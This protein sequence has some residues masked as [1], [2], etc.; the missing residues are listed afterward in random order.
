MTVVAA[1]SGQ[2]AI[3]AVRDGSRVDIAVAD[4]LMPDLDGRALAHALGEAS[5]ARSLPV[6]VISSIGAR[7]P[8][9][10]NVVAWLT[11]PI[12]PST[13]LDAVLD[14]LTHE[15]RVAPA[16]AAPATA[17]VPPGGR[18][19]LR[20]LLA[21]DNPVNQRLALRLLQQMGYSADVATNGLEVIAALEVGTFD[22]VLMDLHMPELDGIEA[23]RRIRRRWQGANG[24]RIVAMTANA[25]AGDRELCL[26]AGMDD[27]ISKP[28][29]VEDL[30]AALELTVAR[31]PGAQ[32]GG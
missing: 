11:K 10:G 9:T 16:S 23:T 17:S 28:I 18:H 14:T 27:Y 12:K 20:I 31:D 21:E 25:M 15:I 5:G 24:P 30:A 32:N 19:P 2:E 4:H 8:L 1:D 13:L 6:V 7:E 26:A 29:R 22:L 3:D